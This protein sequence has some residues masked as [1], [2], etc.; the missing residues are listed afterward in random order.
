MKMNTMKKTKN[1]TLNKKGVDS[2][3][4]FFYKSKVKMKEM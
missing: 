3:T 1:K 2:L 4:N